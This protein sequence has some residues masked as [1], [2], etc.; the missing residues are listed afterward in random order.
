MP[1][2][3]HGG[4]L[5]EIYVVARAFGMKNARRASVRA[6]APGQKPQRPLEQQTEHGRHLSTQ[7]DAAGVLFV[8][9]QQPLDPVSRPKGAVAIRPDVLGIAQQIKGENCE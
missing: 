5:V 6:C 1:K 9:Q 8:I 2:H 3:N 7:P 4:S